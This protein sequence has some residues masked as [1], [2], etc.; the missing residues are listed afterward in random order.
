[1]GRIGLDARLYARHSLRSGFCTVAAQNGATEISIMQ[2]TGHTTVE[3][4][5]R[6]V[7]PVSAFSMNPLAGKL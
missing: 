3:M 2:R 7:R 4:V 5:H 6:Y 1:V